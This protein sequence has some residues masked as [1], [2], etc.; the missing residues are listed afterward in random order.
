M[1]L[2]DFGLTESD[3]QESME[4]VGVL[5]RGSVTEKSEKQEPTYKEI[6]SAGMK[7]T[8]VPLDGPRGRALLG[9]ADEADAPEGGTDG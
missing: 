4:E 6:V 7:A 8:D 5:P 1:P 3:L 9:W 2:K